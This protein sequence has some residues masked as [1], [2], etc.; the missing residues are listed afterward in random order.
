MNCYM[1]FFKVRIFYL[2]ITIKKKEVESEIYSANVVF[3]QS[4]FQG[5]QTGLLV[6]VFDMYN[7]PI[8]RQMTLL[9]AFLSYYK[10]INL[11]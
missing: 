7:Y 4:S 1:F 3:S 11:F 9:L 2:C 10:Q 8:S 6:F 5:A